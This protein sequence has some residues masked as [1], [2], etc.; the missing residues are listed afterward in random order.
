L[1][2][3][4]GRS[5]PA[6]KIICAAVSKKEPASYNEG[7]GTGVRVRSRPSLAARPPS[8]E[9]PLALWGASKSEPYPVA[10]TRHHEGRT[11]LPQEAEGAIHLR[12]RD[13]SPAKKEPALKPSAPIPSSRLFVGVDIASRDCTAALLVPGEKAKCEPTAFAQT[14]EGFAL[15]RASAGGLWT[16][17]RF[18]FGRHGSSR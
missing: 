13:S 5:F 17:A 3:A 14:A 6:G 2:G 12:A 10:L 1:R 11:R 4:Y 7:I 15:L 9:R 18:H 8:T 16:R